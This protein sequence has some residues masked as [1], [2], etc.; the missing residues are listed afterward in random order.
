M[1][2]V[3]RMPQRDIFTETQTAIVRPAE[4]SWIYIRPSFNQDTRYAK[5]NSDKHIPVEE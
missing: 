4:Y 1:Y 5:K 2:E 3:K